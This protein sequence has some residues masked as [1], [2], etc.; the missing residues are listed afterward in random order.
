MSYVE[1]IP[2]CPTCG[3]VPFSPTGKYPW[4]DFEAGDR[5]ECSNPKCA[6][7]PFIVG[8]TPESII[9][10]WKFPT[11][12]DWEISAKRQ[13]FLDG[14]RELLQA[15]ITACYDAKQNHEGGGN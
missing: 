12:R 4:Y 1:T 13:A 7:R 10:R 8:G 2:G 14:L 11:E 6:R 3:K 15:A 9:E 5:I